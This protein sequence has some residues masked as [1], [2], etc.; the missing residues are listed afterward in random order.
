MGYSELGRRERCAFVYGQ[1]PRIIRVVAEDGG[2]THE[3]FH[4]VASDSCPA[5]QQ[6]PA[7]TAES[8]EPAGIL[9]TPKD[10]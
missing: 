2:T 4:P 6:S 7:H 1:A 5:G 9:S 10:G 3:A 8:R